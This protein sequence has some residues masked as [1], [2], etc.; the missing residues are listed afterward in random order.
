MSQKSIFLFAALIACM[1]GTAQIGA[2]ENTIQTLEIGQPAPDFDLPGTDG[3]NHRLSDFSAA[4]VL[5]VVFTCNHCPTA[6]AYEG[7][8]KQLVNDY[9]DRDVAFVAISPN[10]PRAVRL[11]EL[12][13][14][15]LNDSLEEMKL[16]AE[17]QGF[18]F[19]YLYDGDEQAVSGAY[20]PKVTPHVFVFDR[21][22][23]LRYVGR[24]DDNERHPEQAQHHDTRNALEALLAGEAVPVEQTR[25]FGCS[26]K[27]SDKRD[28]VKEAFEAWAKEDVT[29]T[30]IGSS[31]L[32]QVMKNES[33]KLLLVNVWATT[34]GPCVIEFPELVS[35]NRM[36]RHRR[37]ELVTL[38]TD[39]LDRHEQALRFLRQNQASSRNYLFDG[40]PYELF[41]VV[42]P[43]A[44]GAIPLTLL[45]GPGGEIVYR[46][47]GP[48]D[49][50]EVRRAIVGVLGNTYR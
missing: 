16:R 21:E 30:V 33:E 44:S 35:I 18:N 6:Q 47:E 36:Y 3:R 46:H 9:S 23:K 40:T 39:G 2:Q 5:V 11:D 8:I 31:A 45:V 43:R 25:T 34:C 13:W 32:A 4:S 7:R 41:D 10:D 24:I 27:W 20:G 22:R 38:S 14:S 12:G 19:P 42:D 49:P 26:V 17:H 28:S 29:L 48:I 37:F 50:L 15:D 1:A